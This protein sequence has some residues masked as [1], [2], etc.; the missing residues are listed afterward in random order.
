MEKNILYELLFKQLLIYIK[1]M[2][3]GRL[4]NRKINSWTEI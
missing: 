4:F 1:G 3:S 2:L